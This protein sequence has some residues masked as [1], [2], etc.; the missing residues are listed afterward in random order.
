VLLENK[1]KSLI[2]DQA[3][4]E[5]VRAALQ[6]SWLKDSNRGIAQLLARNLN[7]PGPD[8]TK[9]FLLQLN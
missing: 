4:T 2:F 6:K 7:S 1:D 5:M 3:H 9:L 8:P